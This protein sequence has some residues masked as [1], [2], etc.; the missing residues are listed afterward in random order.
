MVVEIFELT[1]FLLD[2]EDVARKITPHF[3]IIILVHKLNQRGKQKIPF[4]IIPTQ[5]K[6]TEEFFLDQL[7]KVQCGSYDSDLSFIKFIF[8]IQMGQSFKEFSLVLIIKPDFEKKFM[9]IWPEVLPNSMKPSILDNELKSEQ[10][11]QRKASEISVRFED[12]AEF[13]EEKICE[14]V[15]IM[16]SLSRK[17]N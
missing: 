17:R 5:E 4:M 9:E 1:T 13:Y 6:E 12:R 2:D 3:G 14:K 7:S 11:F 8:K 15:E 10:T 16:M